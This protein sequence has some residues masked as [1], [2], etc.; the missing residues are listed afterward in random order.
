MLSLTF[1]LTSVAAATETK[2]IADGGACGTGA[3]KVT[4]E[5]AGCENKCVAKAAAAVTPAAD[6]ATDKATGTDT[7]AGDANAARRL[8]A[9]DVAK[10]ETLCKDKQT[11]CLAENMT[12]DTCKDGCK[13]VLTVPAVTDKAGKETTAA[14]P[15]HCE[16]DCECKSGT[17]ML[18]ATMV[19]LAAISLL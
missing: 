17:T 16:A 18:S 12:K 1:M 9:A 4:T 14:V 13:W 2:K 6:K 7:K 15:E 10:K 3:T 5:D 8:A 11:T 19:L